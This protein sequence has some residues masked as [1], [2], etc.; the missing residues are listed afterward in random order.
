V[1]VAL[2]Q[3]T[4]A[5]LGFALMGVPMAGLWALLV[6]ILAIAQLSPMLVILPVIFYVFSTSG[7][8]VGSVIFAIWCVLV[9]LCDN[10]LKPLFLSR[11]V[12]VPMLV[13][14]IGSLGG[15]LAMGILGLFIGAVVLAV[16]YQ[17]WMAW[18]LAGQ[19]EQAV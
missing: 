17:I 16:G 11:G 2:I 12:Q 18:A 8:T 10:V 15:M 6:L 5:A 9:G 14:M 4:L 1:G 13:M 19:P 3:S 7:G